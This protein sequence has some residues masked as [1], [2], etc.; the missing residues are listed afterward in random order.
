MSR[1]DVR[2]PV[3]FEDRNDIISM[4]ENL[5]TDEE[6]I[7]CMPHVKRGSI[8]AFRAHVTRGTYLGDSK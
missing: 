2:S 3:S 4:I 1:S 8:S 6:I 5:W 7:E